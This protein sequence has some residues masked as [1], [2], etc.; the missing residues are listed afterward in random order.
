[1][2]LKYVTLAIL[3]CILIVESQSSPQIRD[4][5]AQPSKLKV[6]SIR[7]LKKAC[8]ECVANRWNCYV[9]DVKTC[10]CCCVRHWFDGMHCTCPG[11]NC[12]LIGL[13]P[14]ECYCL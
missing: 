14:C 10:E 12:F 9:G 13:S 1:M 7:E 4:K 6:E 5:F 11:K 2:V 3:V 8:F